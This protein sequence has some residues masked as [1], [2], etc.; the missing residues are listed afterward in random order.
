MR[1][2]VNVV[3]SWKSF[4][5]AMFHVKH[6]SAIHVVWLGYLFSSCASTLLDRITGTDTK[7][8]YIIWKLLSLAV[9]VRPCES[10]G[11]FFE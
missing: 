4:C 11:G 1:Y 7:S 9:F 3:A 6:T 8:N 10:D 5:V 2:F